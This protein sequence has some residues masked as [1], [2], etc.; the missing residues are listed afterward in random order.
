MQIGSAFEMLLLSFALADRINSLRREKEQAQA[1]TLAANTEKLALLRDSEHELE[2]RVA[3][4]TRQLEQANVELAAH[5]N[6][7]QHLAHH[8]PLT[9]LAN[10]VLLDLRLEH[11]LHGCRRSGQ[12]LAVLLVDLDDFKPI[13]DTYGHAVGDEVLCAVAERLR[14]ATRNADTVARLG[15]D[16][17]VVVLENLH[18]E[19]EARQVAAKLAEALDAPLPL[20]GVTLHIGASVGLA[21]YPVDGTTARELLQAADASMYRSKQQR[22]PMRPV[23][24]VRQPTDEA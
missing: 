6:A 8:D 11:A 5:R 7:L 24:H 20:A 13:N 22:R 23:A 2:A 15:G 18:H 3:E 17:F 9:G 12:G 1:E 16:E 14:A 21:C 19:A 10:R 4:R